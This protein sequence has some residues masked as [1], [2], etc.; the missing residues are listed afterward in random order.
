MIKIVKN[1]NVE[2]VER[3]ELNGRKYLFMTNDF[4]SRPAYAKIGLRP[5]IGY[6]IMRFKYGKRRS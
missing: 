4:T 2:W 6:I 3:T 1:P 5:L